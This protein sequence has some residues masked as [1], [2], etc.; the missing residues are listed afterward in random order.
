MGLAVADPILV[1]WSA[2]GRPASEP[3]VGSE[4]RPGDWLDTAL[5]DNDRITLY[6]YG[7]MG[8]SMIIMGVYV[9]SKGA[10]MFVPNWMKEMAD[11]DAR[12][13][14]GPD[15]FADDDDEDAN[16]VPQSRFWTPMLWKRSHMIF[17]TY[18]LTVSLLVVWEFSYSAEFE[19]NV[20]FYIVVFKFVQII[21]DQVLAAYMREQLLI[22]PLM[23]VIGISEMLVTLG[24][25]DFMDFTM[26][27][28]VELAVMIL[29]RLYLDPLMK[30]T[31]KLWPRWKMMIKR[32][33]AKKRRMTRRK[34]QRKRRSGVVSTKK[35]AR[36]GG[37]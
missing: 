16:A 24:A 10:G 8:A 3:N 28:F 4:D 9:I 6:R 1:H 31:A 33:F 17:T 35:L 13:R 12:R 20:Y 34:R 14:E 2:V 30:E 19:D 37:C 22:T 27:Y 26:S 29:E 11:D 21:M 36:V 7:R 25:S 15:M 32:R 23:V 18:M 5:L